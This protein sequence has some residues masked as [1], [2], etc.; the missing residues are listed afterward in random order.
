MQAFPQTAPIVG[1][2]FLLRPT[3]I[4]GLTQYRSLAILFVENGL[5]K[6]AA[7]HGAVFR[8]LGLGH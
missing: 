3:N 1:T 8:A 5:E 2:R 4:L 6:P 7:G